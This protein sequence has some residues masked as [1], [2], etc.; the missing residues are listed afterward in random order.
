MRNFVVFPEYNIFINACFG[1]GHV[2]LPAIHELQT[3]FLQ[4]GT[5]LDFQ[6]VDI[7]R[8]LWL[9]HKISPRR[10]RRTVCFVHYQ[11]AVMKSPWRSDLTKQKPHNF[12]TSKHALEVKPFLPLPC[13]VQSTM[14]PEAKQCFF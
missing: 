12:P 11:V 8:I 14:V 1:R 13:S 9:C 4:P 6:E 7:H 5:L 2:S 3:P 10:V